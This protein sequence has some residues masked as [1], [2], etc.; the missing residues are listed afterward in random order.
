MSAAGR[1]AD[2]QGNPRRA[3]QAIGPQPGARLRIALIRHAPTAGNLERRYIGA[4]DEALSPAGRTLARDVRA[5]LSAVRPRL[6]FTS[7]MRRCDET[8]AIL[9]PDLSPI[10]VP[11]LA[12]MRF[13]AFEGKTYAELAGDARYQAWVDAGCAAACPGGEGQDGFVA[14]VRGAFEQALD[15]CAA[16]AASAAGEARRGDSANAGIAASECLAVPWPGS[17]TL[18]HAA[19]VVHA[20]TI[21]AAMSELAEPPRAYWDWKAAYCGG[22]TAQALRTENGWRLTHAEELGPIVE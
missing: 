4:T 7:G 22:Y 10:H 6:L 18:L 16:Q 11:G 20:G 17:P 13:G 14:R 9:F 19:F 15:E 2:A 3:R 1:G 8:A 12:E 5:R 21:M